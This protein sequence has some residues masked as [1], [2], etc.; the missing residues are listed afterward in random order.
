[1]K[2]MPMAKKA[3]N[4]P[5]HNGTKKEQK[6]K[7]MQAAGEKSWETR[8]RNEL[9]RT[10]VRIGNRSTAK[11]KER[12][13]AVSSFLLSLLKNGHEEGCL[14]CGEQ[15]KN[16]LDSH[17]IDGNRQNNSSLNLAK[18]CASCHRVLDKAKTPR[19]ALRDLKI[20]N[21]AKRLLH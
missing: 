7:R 6:S 9:R 4:K 1:M 8:R 11:Q 20:R 15:M 17:H 21:S 10:Q 13:L 14:V 18:L 12:I 3:M 5:V 19:E 2:T 16:T